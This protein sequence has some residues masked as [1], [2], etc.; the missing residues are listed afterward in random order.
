M[1]QIEQ[2]RPLADS[3]RFLQRA[4]N[5]VGNLAGAKMLAVI[6]DVWKSNDI[7]ARPAGPILQTYY[8]SSL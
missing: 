5:P 6:S 8:I 4:D 3:G 1:R 2:P 7:T